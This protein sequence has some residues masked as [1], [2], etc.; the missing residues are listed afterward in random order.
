MEWVEVLEVPEDSEFGYCQS[1]G[2]VSSFM[3]HCSQF[4]IHFLL[5]KK[6]IT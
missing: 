3:I 5:H 1:S 2:K 6:H 4:F